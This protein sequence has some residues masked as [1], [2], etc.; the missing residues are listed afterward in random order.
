MNIRQKTDLVKLSNQTLAELPEDILRPTYD[1]A[2][3]TPGIVHI[4]LGNF[5]RGA[6]GVVSASVDADRA[7]A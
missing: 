5:H 1:R 2:A 7:G 4:G 3:L 6:S